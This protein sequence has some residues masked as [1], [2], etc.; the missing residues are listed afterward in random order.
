M[1]RSLRTAIILAAAC[2]LWPSVLPARTSIARRA[3]LKLLVT[4]CANDPMVLARVT[5]VLRQGGQTIKVVS[6]DTSLSGRV[7]LWFENV[8]CCQTAEVIVV[9]RSGGPEHHDTLTR[10]GCRQCGPDY[11][12]DWFQAEPDNT[13]GLCCTDRW[14]EDPS[15]WHIRYHH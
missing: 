10:G 8:A 12:D 2:L 1:K 5:V 11:V 14:S 4:D 15:F 7:T 6:G 3:D 9:P 13:C